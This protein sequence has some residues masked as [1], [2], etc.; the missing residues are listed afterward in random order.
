[1]TSYASDLPGGCRTSDLLEARAGQLGDGRVTLGAL[2]AVLGNRSFGLLLLLFALPNLVPLPP[3][4]STVFGLPLLLL[5]A[6]MACGRGLPWLPAWLLRRSLPRSSFD[7]M[8]ARTLP[9]MRRLERW[10]KPRYRR[11]TG[12]QAERLL[13]GWCA[14][15][16]TILALPIPFANMPPALCIVLIAL[17]LLERDGALVLAGSLVGLVSVGIGLTVGYGLVQGLLLVT[18]G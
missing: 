14:L 12:P 7:L 13:G 11:C 17:G 8:L 4:S 9:S 1:M 5:S 15:Q 18:G 6:Q 10:L 2:I 16:A 3:G